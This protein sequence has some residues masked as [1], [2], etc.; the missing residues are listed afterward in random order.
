[1]KTKIDF[2]RIIDF[3]MNKSGKDT[4]T[5]VVLIGVLLLVISLPMGKSTAGNKNIKSQTDSQA[6]TAEGK[7][8]GSSDSTSD[9]ARAYEEYLENKIESLLSKV[10][11]V[12]KTQVIV[13]V[14]NTAEKIIAT[15]SDSSEEN[16]SENDSTGGSRISQKTQSTSEN[17]M[18]DTSDGNAPFVKRENM[19]KIE[20]VIVAAQGGGDGTVE[21]D[22]TSAI[23]ALLGVAAHKIKV[24]KMS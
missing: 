20:G 3:F 5:I 4:I 14:K 21:A 19:P 22:I 12:G 16:V 8:G 1:M 6:Y 24:M 15:D 2:K 9:S 18:Y 11:G 23:E 7:S 17:I 13:S 10:E